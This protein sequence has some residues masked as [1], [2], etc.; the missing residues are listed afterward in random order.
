[1]RGKEAIKEA[2]MANRC[3]DSNKAEKAKD[4]AA[5][6]PTN[7][8]APPPTG[9]KAKDVTAITPTNETAAPPTGETEES[10]NRLLKDKVKSI[11]YELDIDPLPMGTGQDSTCTSD[12]DM[13]VDNIDKSEHSE[14][15][16]IGPDAG[17]MYPMR[18]HCQGSEASSWLQID[19]HMSMGLTLVCGDIYDL[20]NSNSNSLEIST[21]SA[22]RISQH[23]E[24]EE[25][26]FDEGEG[27][28][29]VE[30]LS[31]ENIVNVSSVHD[32]DNSILMH[33]TSNPTDK[34]EEGYF[35]VSPNV[36][37][38]HANVQIPNYISESSC[39]TSD[40]VGY[41]IF[42]HIRQHPI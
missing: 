39:D 7:E 2:L 12:L 41:Q 42:T 26:P 24:D 15:G 11:T 33:T 14:Y 37:L 18:S 8:T 20:Q 31:N 1:M 19:K 5:T 9:E 25:Q 4:V 29:E 27:A 22:V 30:L 10:K 6:P 28:I 13:D 16:S 40:G 34:E 17:C 23:S 38:T 32:N 21:M 35:S 36:S 3:L